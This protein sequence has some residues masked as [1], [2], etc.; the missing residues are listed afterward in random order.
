MTKDRDYILGTHDA[1]IARL[2][3]Q[4]RVWRPTALG[5][6]QRCGVTTGCTVIDAG[7]GPGYAAMDLAEI[8]GPKGRVIAIDRSRRFLD[9]LRETAKARGLAN[10]EI[11]DAELTDDVWPKG[12][13]DFIWCRWVFAFVREPAAVM[14]R[15]AEALKPGGALLSQ[16]YYDYRGWRLAPADAEFERFVSVIMQSWRDEGGEP[17]IGL[18]MPSLATEAGLHIERAEPEVRVTRRGDYFWEWPAAFVSNSLERLVELKKITQE[19]ASRILAAWK[20]AEADPRTLMF[21]PGVL[22]LA[23]RKPR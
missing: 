5:F 22:M 10:I 2:G 23:A 21:T 3:L 17:D 14:R 19:D 13:A 4:H 8:A 7:C 18:Q 15:M 20:K 12:E 6:W 9:V 11:V 1:E 16:E